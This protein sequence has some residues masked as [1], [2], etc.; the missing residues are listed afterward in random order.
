MK[1]ILVYFTDRNA[2]DIIGKQ[3]TV[4][5]HA[6]HEAIRKFLVGEDPN[7]SEFIVTIEDGKQQIHKNPS[8]SDGMEIDDHQTAKV[9]NDRSA[10]IN[11]LTKILKTQEENLYW[12]RV[13]GVWYLVAA[14]LL[15]IGFVLSAFKSF[16]F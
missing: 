12:S 3:K 1:S 4:S 9:L 11:L 6:R 2:T 7:Q 10:E 15:F 14:V 8:Y 13:V 16:R 5:A